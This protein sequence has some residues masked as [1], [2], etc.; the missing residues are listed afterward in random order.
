MLGETAATILRSIEVS[1]LATLLA[2]SWS[3]PLAYYMASRNPGPIVESIVESLVGIPTVLLGLLLY[4]LLSSSGPLGGLGLLFTKRA[5]ILGEALLVTPLIVSSLY[6]STRAKVSQLL[7]LATTLGA[8][9]PGAALLVLS[10]TAADATAACI[11]GFSRA[12]GEL[13]VAMMLGG[14]IAGYTR[15]MTTAIALDVSKGNFEEAVY[16]GLALLATMI[17]ASTALKLLQRALRP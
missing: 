11:M 6:R 12:I 5:M 8:A 14:N 15:V 7:E 9:G 4:M 10:E 16:L 13:G 3:L 1:G 17:V 2:A